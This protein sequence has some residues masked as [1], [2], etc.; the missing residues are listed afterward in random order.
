M[1][2]YRNQDHME[3]AIEVS[4]EGH[5]WNSGIID[6]KKWNKSQAGVLF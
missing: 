1:D 4:S 5:R 6:T 2:S 3:I